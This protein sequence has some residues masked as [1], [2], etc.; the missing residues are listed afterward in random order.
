MSYRQQH[1][2]N[3]NVKREAGVQHNTSGSPFWLSIG[4][5]S[6]TSRDAALD[7]IQGYINALQKALDAERAS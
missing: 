3:L 6:D 4:A 7:G 2:V 1:Y 5:F